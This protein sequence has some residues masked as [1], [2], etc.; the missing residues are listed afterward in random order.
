M[1]ANAALNPDLAIAAIN[2]AGPPWDNVKATPPNVP[3]PTK[4]VTPAIACKVA[5]RFSFGL[6]QKPAMSIQ[7]SGV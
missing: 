7:E 4:A 5:F 1:R 3:N 6:Q 2:A